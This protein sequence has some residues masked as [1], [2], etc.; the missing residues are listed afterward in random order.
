MRSFT[1]ENLAKLRAYLELNAR[2]LATDKKIK[3]LPYYPGKEH[4]REYLWT[5]VE[6]KELGRIELYFTASSS[7][8]KI[9]GIYVESERV[10]SFNFRQI[11]DLLNRHYNSKIIEDADD[12][13]NNLYSNWD[14]K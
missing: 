4:L 13:F 8:M 6:V 2:K 10:D 7:L 14:N 3:K 12:A 5:I 9:K 11:Y 1:D